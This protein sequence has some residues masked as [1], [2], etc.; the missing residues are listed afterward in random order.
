MTLA[1]IAIQR[2]HL[3]AAGAGK[4]ELWERRFCDRRWR[5]AQ[6]GISAGGVVLEIDACGRWRWCSWSAAASAP[7]GSTPSV[8]AFYSF[9]TLPFLP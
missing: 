1:R 7:P 5:R 2:R 4:P 9:S 6:C 8:T 3:R